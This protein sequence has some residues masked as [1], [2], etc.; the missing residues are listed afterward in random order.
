MFG[1][2]K[3]GVVTTDIFITS[4]CGDTWQQKIMQKTTT[5]NDWLCTNSLTACGL[6]RLIKKILQTKNI[7]LVGP[8]LVMA[9]WTPKS[10][11]DTAAWRAALWNI[12]SFLVGQTQ[13]SQ[14]PR[15]TNK[16]LAHDDD[17]DGVDELECTHRVRTH[18][19]L[20]IVSNA[21]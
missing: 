10:G 9:P 3:T 8:L 13:L 17:A 21:T 16:Q 12:V 6:S 20:L 5:T 1:I 7:I 18:A 19:V 11:P 14:R 2:L 15:C 4:T